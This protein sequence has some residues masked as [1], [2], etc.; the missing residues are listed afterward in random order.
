MRERAK[1]HSYALTALR[2]FERLRKLSIRNLKK[3]NFDPLNSKASVFQ[4]NLLS[5]FKIR[6]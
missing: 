1:T 4:N 5:S 6:L 2:H 3:N